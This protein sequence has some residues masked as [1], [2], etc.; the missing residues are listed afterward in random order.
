[1]TTYKWLISFF[2]LSILVIALGAYL[3][4][5]EQLGADGFLLIGIILSL[6]S[7]VIAIFE[8][9]QST[10]IQMSRKILWTLAF[11]MFGSVT[12]FFYLI[13]RKNIVNNTQVTY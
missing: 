6:V 5:T 11:F 9:M 2:V 12:M 4:I 13:F 7:Y 8:V 3:K 1:M 10:R